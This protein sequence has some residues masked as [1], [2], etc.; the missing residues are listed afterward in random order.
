MH[1]FLPNV[2]GI[3][4]K[5]DLDQFPGI[6][7]TDPNSEEQYARHYQVSWLEMESDQAIPINLDGEPI[8]AR[9]IRFEVQPGAVKLV[10]PR[11]CNLL[12]P[13]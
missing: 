1:F 10:L 3:F 11:D 9:R 6:G 7:N 8:E 2:R 5:D 4:K 13:Q 12:S